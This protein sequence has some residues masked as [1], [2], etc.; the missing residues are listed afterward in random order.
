MLGIILTAIVIFI[1]FTGI[2]VLIS[3]IFTKNNFGGGYYNK[4]HKEE[5]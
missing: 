4:Q 5:R 1:I 2:I 3:Y